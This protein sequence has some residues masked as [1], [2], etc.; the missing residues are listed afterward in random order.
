MIWINKTLKD[1]WFYWVNVL[2]ELDTATDRRYISVGACIIKY[3][4]QTG[5][6]KILNQKPVAAY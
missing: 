5:F 3:K 2:E 1:I 6:V 4:E